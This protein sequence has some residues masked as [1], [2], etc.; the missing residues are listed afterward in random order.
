MVSNPNDKTKKVESKKSSFLGSL[1]GFFYNH[2]KGILKF[3]L[4]FSVIVF[5]AFSFMKELDVYETLRFSMN[6]IEIFFIAVVDAIFSI[7]K[8]YVPF[9]F[10]CLILKFI[11]I[12]SRKLKVEYIFKNT[13]KVQSLIA[14]LLSFIFSV[15]F[16][17]D[18]LLLT[19]Y[20]PQ[21]IRSSVEIFILSF[22]SVLFTLTSM[23]GL[24]S[25][26]EPVLVKKD[27][28]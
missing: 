19:R 14:F 22:V 12:K 13:F 21:L 17:V 4:V 8:F 1:L 25:S 26:I 10:V 23:H 16:Y 7:I 6:P 20:S 24:L 3:T 27:N 18:V 28:K 5:F 11:M 9:V 15:I 2:T